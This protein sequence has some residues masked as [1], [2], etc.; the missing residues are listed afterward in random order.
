MC[1][2]K[3]SLQLSSLCKGLFKVPGLD[4]IQTHAG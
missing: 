2:F 1:A 4:D 3:L